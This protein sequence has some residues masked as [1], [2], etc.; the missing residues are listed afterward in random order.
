[1]L[2]DDFVENGFDVQRL[3]RVIA[4]TEVFH[5]ESKADFEIREDHQEYW[6]VFPLVRL[7]P[8]QVASSIAQ[9]T[10]LT[11]L[12]G[13]A[14]ILKRLVSF[15]ETLDFVKRYGDQGEN[16]FG[17]RGETVTQRL[18]LLNGD[19]VNNRLE[20][21]LGS[22]VR[23]ANLA[24]SIQ[25]AVETVYLAAL[26]RLPSTNEMNYF[27]QQFNQAG[28]REEQIKDLYWTLINS[29]EFVWNH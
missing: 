22:P 19:V 27:C 20:N 1:V 10:S 4:A 14:H 28:S 9:S 11:T 16:E 26:T 24:P 12:D 17:E 5:L 18:L 15:G 6:A 21:G 13:T 7:R 23:I 8:E 25:K 29:V 2:V 3:I